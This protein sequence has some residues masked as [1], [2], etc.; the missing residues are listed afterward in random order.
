MRLASEWH[1]LLRVKAR[2]YRQRR[3][4]LHRAMQTTRRNTYDDSS[5][6]PRRACDCSCFVVLWACRYRHKK[7]TFASLA[8]DECHGSRRLVRTRGDRLCQGLAFLSQG[9]TSSSSFAFNAPIERSRGPVNKR[10]LLT[11]DPARPVRRGTGARSA[12]TFSHDPRSVFVRAKAKIIG[13]LMS[14]VCVM[15]S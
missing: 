9:A 2:K 3:H 7:M 6:N 8:V 13:H 1:A 4:L 12:E 15:G 5:P 10:A 14:P 11:R